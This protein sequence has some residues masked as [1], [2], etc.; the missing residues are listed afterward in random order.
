MFVLVS[1]R[2]QSAGYVVDESGDFHPRST[3]GQCTMV[4]LVEKGVMGCSSGARRLLR[5]C[6]G[7]A[8]ASHRRLC[9][10]IEK[11]DKL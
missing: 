4:M 2:L 5:V 8:K 11:D 1:I 6:E 7:Y 9:G 3:N 10:K